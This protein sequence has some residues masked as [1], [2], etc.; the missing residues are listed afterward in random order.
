MNSDLNKQAAE[1]RRLA[2]AAGHAVLDAGWSAAIPNSAPA[3]SCSA[4]AAMALNFLLGFTGVLSFGHAAYFGLGAYG[5]GM[6]IS[7]LVPS[8]GARHPGRHAGRHGRRA[9]SS[10]R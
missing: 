10:G 3:S 7:Y 4:L 1:R 9:R 8:T 2:A 6:T 5:V